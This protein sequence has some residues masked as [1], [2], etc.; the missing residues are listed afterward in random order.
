MAITSSTSH[1]IYSEKQT[2][3]LS[4]EKKEISTEQPLRSEILQQKIFVLKLC[5]L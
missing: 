3:Q 5:S 2:K 1:S 4:R